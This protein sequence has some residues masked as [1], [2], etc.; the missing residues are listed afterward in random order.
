MT[1]ARLIRAILLAASVGVGI[2]TELLTTGMY[3]HAVWTAPALVFVELVRSEL[4]KAGAPTPPGA[5]P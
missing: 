1:R 5:A 4:R 2:A 3:S